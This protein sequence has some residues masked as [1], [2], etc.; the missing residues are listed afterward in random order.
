MRPSLLV[1]T[2][3]IASFMTLGAATWSRWSVSAESDGSLVPSLSLIDQRALQISNAVDVTSSTTSGAGPLHS[4]SNDA[5]NTARAYVGRTTDSVRVLQAVAPEFYD[6]AD[7]PVWIVIF[8]GG[9][10]P[11]QRPAWIYRY[12]I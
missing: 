5:I 11:G 2:V 8:P 7:R 12:P 10:R 6:S 4:S 3:L 9:E 1:A